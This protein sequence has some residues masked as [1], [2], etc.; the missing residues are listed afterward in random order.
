MEGVSC[1]VT[2]LVQ[3]KLMLR[4]APNIPTVS[5]LSY[6]DFQTVQEYFS[7][8]AQI[9]PVWSE[10][11]MWKILFI[12]V[13]MNRRIACVCVKYCQPIL[14]EVMLYTRVRTWRCREG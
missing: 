11:F 7:V 14:I 10:G 3:T 4:L 2:P 12:R 8:Q 1:K 9:G 5:A 13:K 6:F